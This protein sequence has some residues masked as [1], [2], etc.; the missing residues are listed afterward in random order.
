MK[1]VVK[2]SVLALFLSASLVIVGCASDEDETSTTTAGTTTTDATDATDETD[3]ADATDATDTADETDAAD[4]TDATDS[5]DDTDATDATDATEACPDGSSCNNG[6][7]CT[8]AGIGCGGG[9]DN[10]LSQLS[11]LANGPLQESLDDGDVNLV[12]EFDGDTSDGTEF[13]LNMFIA[14]LAADNADCDITKDTCNWELDLA[15]FDAN[16]EPLIAFNNAVIDGTSLTAGGTDGIFVLSLP[17]AGINLE[18]TVTSARIVGEVT[19]EGD[20]ITGL[21]GILAGAVPK[22]GLLDAV[23]NLGDD[24]PISPSAIENILNNVL[25][26]DID[27]LDAEGNPGT[28]GVKESY[29]V[30]IPFRGIPANIVGTQAA[31]DDETPACAEPPTTFSS[32]GF[33]MVELS[34]GTG[35]TEGQAIDVDGI[36]TDP[37]TPE[38]CMAE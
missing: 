7:C 23:G 16:C 14:E 33:R 17:I 27:G 2:F 26:V 31:A 24:L 36:C 8:C 25:S 29:S 20:A 19:K 11:S 35:G 28:D 22:K 15:A 32:V 10:A 38:M 6:K 21:S 1:T 3:A 12:A 4:A 37:A 18:I 30:G 13:S 9:L 34:L 5:A